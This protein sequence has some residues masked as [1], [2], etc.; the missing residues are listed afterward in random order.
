VTACYCQFCSGTLDPAQEFRFLVET[1]TLDDPTH[2][3]RIRSLPATGDGRPLRVC[4]A[5]QGEIEA[6]PVR[7]RIA[8][9]RAQV[10]RQIR[11]GVMAAVGI[12]SVGFLMMTALGG[13]RA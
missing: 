1:D 3:N 6:H 12:L 9:E 4:K 10:Q 11:T 13:P 7:F 2:L 8:V 5:C